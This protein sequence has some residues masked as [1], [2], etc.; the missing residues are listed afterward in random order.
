MEANPPPTHPPTQ[1]TNPISL[2]SI[3]ILQPRHGGTVP[4]IYYSLV[5]VSS[6]MN[7][8]LSVLFIYLVVSMH[9][10]TPSAE[11]SECMHRCSGLWYACYGMCSEPLDCGWCV[12]NKKTCVENCRKKR[13]FQSTY[14]PYSGIEKTGRQ[15]SDQMTTIHDQGASKSSFTDV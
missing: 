12:Q 10:K 13:V 3:F 8:S 4:V 7:S 9:Q 15:L 2:Y 14:G 11:Y 5:F 6:Q 1:P